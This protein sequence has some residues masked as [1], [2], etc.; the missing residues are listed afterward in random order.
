MQRA[1]RRIQWQ[2]IKLSEE[3]YESA[4][5]FDVD[6]DGVLDIVSGGFWYQGPDWTKH[7]LCDVMAEGEYYDDFSTIPFDVDGDE[8]L[9]VVTGGWFGEELV[10]RQNPKGR[11]V[12]WQTHLIYRTGNVETTRAW[13]VDG[14]GEL[15][16]C[17]NTPGAGLTFFKHNKST[18]GFDRI[19]VSESPQGHGL[20]FGDV[21]GNGKG[22]FVVRNGFWEP[23]G[24]PLRDPWTFHPEFEL[25][26]ASVP[27]VVADVNQ[28]G[29]NEIVVG[30]AHGYGLDY[31]APTQDAQGGRTWTKHPIDPWFSQY[32]DMIWI[33]VDDDGENELVTGCRHRAH[34]GAEP[35]EDDIVGLFIFKWNG[36]SFTKQVVD[37]GPVPNHSGTGIFFQVADLDG[38]GLLDIVAPG[39]EGLYIFRNLGLES[40]G[41]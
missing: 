35:G 18:G 7:K 33:D 19:V 30:Q 13:D 26:T 24:D 15:E 14:D 9:D 31:Y 41:G 34:N 37:Y 39:K 4:G 6:N 5:V 11:P 36:E 29:V 40:I 17:P 3:R 27:I 21:L 25:G 22:C 16:I 38:N 10:W 28:D 23:Q 20:G 2:K 8:Y 1:T 12:E 32:H